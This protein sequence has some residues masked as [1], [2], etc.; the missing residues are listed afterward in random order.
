MESEMTKS[1]SYVLP[2]HLIFST[3]TG[4]IKLNRHVEEL[5]NKGFKWS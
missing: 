2:P 5:A 1:I 3:K 4:H